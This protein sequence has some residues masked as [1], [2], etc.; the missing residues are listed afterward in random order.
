MKFKT[1]IFTSLCIFLLTS[2]E[3]FYLVS[4]KELSMYNNTDSPVVV[5]C[6]YFTE[7]N[8]VTIPAYT[9]VITTVKGYAENIILFTNGKYYQNAQDSV[10]LLDYARTSQILTPNCSWIKLTNYTGTTI[11]STTLKNT[12]FYYDEKGNYVG[13]TI[14]PYQSRYLKLLNNYNFSYSDYLECYAN[15][16]TYISNRSYSIPQNGH[17]KTIFLY[18]S[19]LRPKY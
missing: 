1:I 8:S 15:N 14:A 10:S 7:G 4:T 6:S 16:T 17:T 13:S 3:L 11:S 12:Y 9:E 5:S 19:D 18:N 2:C